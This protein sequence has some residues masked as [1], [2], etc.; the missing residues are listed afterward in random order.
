MAGS[1]SLMR[2]M[3][4][5]TTTAEAVV[6]ALEQNGLEQI[7]CLPGVQNDPLFDV[8]F[9][10][11]DRIRV[12]HTRHEQ[13]CAYMALGAALATG[14]PSAYNVVPGPG[15]LNTTAA[16]AT[17]YSTNAPVLALVGQ[18]PSAHIDGGLGLLHE[19]PDQL[20]ITRTLTK[21]A[22]RVRAPIEAPALVD[23]AFRRMLNGR[24]RPVGLECAMDVWAK[25]GAVERLGTPAARSELPIDDD[26][27]DAAAK[28][29][30]QAKRPLIMV[31]GGAQEASTEVT[32][33]AELLQ[34]PVCALRMGHGV[35][36]SRHELSITGPIGHHLWRQTDVVLAIGTRLQPQRMNWGMDDEL[37]IVRIDIDPEEIE[38]IAPPAVGIVGYAAPVL[39]RLLDR[40]PRLLQ[41]RGSPLDELGALKGRFRNDMA[42]LQPQL[43]FLEAIRA[44][45]PEDGIYV[46]D[47]TQVSYVS[48]VAFPVYGPRTFISPGYQGTLGWGLAAGL[49]VKAAKPGAAVVAV[50]GD[51]GF[52]FNVQELATAVQHGIATVTIVFNDGAFGNVRRTQKSQLGN[53]LIATD[54]TNP[55]FVKLA[56]SF[57]VAGYRVT[58]PKRLRLALRDA[59]T[60]G[61]PAVI[62][63]ALRRDAEPLG[64]R[65][66]AASARARPV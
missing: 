13:G 45:L 26:A 15:F 3:I 30:G 42:K 39:A 5:Q 51:G 54:L 46:D 60:L 11:S 8:L 20:G 25:R 63:V 47:L 17:A 2:R 50:T 31:G 43:A 64:V 56:E 19:I 12:V 16:L 33:V 1:W 57:G 48:R 53:R 32:A 21:W 36:D 55:D 7:F 29:L 27:I 44:E 9:D 66:V 37:Q 6:A 59:L 40:L 62:E 18:I 41:K 38:R 52:M 23:E 49:G 58:S 28:L 35:V 22:E 34:A 61:G 24:P 10:A 14:R 4:T 65:S